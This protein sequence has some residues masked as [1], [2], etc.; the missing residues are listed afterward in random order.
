MA[1]EAGG[2]WGA[3]PGAG[4]V[5][6]PVSAE[7]GLPFLRPPQ[8]GA[9]TPCP[10]AAPGAAPSPAPFSVLLGP[11]GGLWGADARGA[12]ARQD[13]LPRR[14]P[15]CAPG[16]WPR[17][18]RAGMEGNLAVASVAGAGRRAGLAGPGPGRPW[19]LSPSPP[20]PRVGL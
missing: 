3:P 4:K 13:L 15:E 9:W 20:R 11:G 19:L 7:P 1:V 18:P 17:C 14:A 8:D 2:P 5:A 12:E 16:P 10:C 6:G